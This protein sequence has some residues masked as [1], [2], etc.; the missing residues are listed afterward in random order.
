MTLAT[1]VNQM[2]LSD[3]TLAALPS[4]LASD[5]LAGR[6]IIVSGGGSGIGRATAWLAARLGAQV[7]VTG[8]TLEKLQRVSAALTTRGLK[9]DAIAVDIRDRVA[10]DALF[11]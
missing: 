8:R 9:C 6:V 2:S 5:L 11:T 1:D 7:I 10:V 3:H 4:S